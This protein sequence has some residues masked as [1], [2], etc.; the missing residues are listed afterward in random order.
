MEAP[1]S[2]LTTC[3][4]ALLGLSI[5]APVGPIGLLCIRRT[6]VDGWRIGLATGLGAATADAVYGAI[7][8]GGLGAVSGLLVRHRFALQLAGGAFLLWIGIRT[9]RHRPPANAAPTKG[10]GIP[11]AF[12]ATFALTLANPM[13]ILSFVGL[14]AAMGLGS[15]ASTA[16]S[17]L[18]VFGVFVGSAAWWLGLSAAVSGLRDRV[19]PG[20]MLWINRISGC[21]VAAYG[22]K[23]LAG[24]LNSKV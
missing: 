16:D 3:R 17:V 14:F 8:A 11:G 24:L 4:G 9:L 13:T 22:L 10:P 2:F 21:A 1:E 23:T 5:A 15:G 18:L 7:A 19:T 6:L 12:A 20:G